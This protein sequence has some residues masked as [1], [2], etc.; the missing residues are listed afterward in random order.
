MKDVLDKFMKEQ[1][2]KMSGSAD[3]WTLE[4]RKFP[5]IDV[6]SPNYESVTHE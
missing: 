2:L 3:D 1:L 4:L 5:L 6:D